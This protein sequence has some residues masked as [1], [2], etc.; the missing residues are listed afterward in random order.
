[1]T[2]GRSR[3]GRGKDDGSAVVEFVLVTVVLLPLFMALIQLGFVLYVRNTL[4]ASTAEGARYAAN[5]DR[6]PAAGADMT[7][8]I[9]RE[10]LD[11]SFA[12]DVSAGHEDVDGVPTVYVDVKAGLPL[13]GWFAAVPGALHVRGHAVVEVP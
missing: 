13:F 2:V 5:A 11:D 3:P 12:D 4:V 7:R 9:V 6:D 8:T 1:M 10:S